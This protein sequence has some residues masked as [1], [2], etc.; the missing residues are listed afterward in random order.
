MGNNSNTIGSYYSHRNS[1]L[2]TNSDQSFLAMSSK[3]KS[4]RETL[5]VTYHRQF[6]AIVKEL[7]RE[8]RR[9]TSSAVEIN[10]KHELET[11]VIEYNSIVK[12]ETI[13]K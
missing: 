6:E 5:N 9:P 1:T 8:M 3:R 2:F 13:P 4:L 11:L 10:L 12:K 7:C